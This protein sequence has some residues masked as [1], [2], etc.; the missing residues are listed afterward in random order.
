MATEVSATAEA[1]ANKLAELLRDDTALDRL[2]YRQTSTCLELW[3][4]THPANRTDEL[5]LLEAFG[6]LYEVFPTER[7]EPRLLNPVD[8]EDVELFRRALPH[9]THDVASAA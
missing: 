2:L 4:V 8:F 3:M 6:T 7:L 1:I 5:R 9:D